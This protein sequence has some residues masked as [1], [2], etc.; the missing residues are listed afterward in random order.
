[1]RNK[2]I[3]NTIEGAAITLS[4]LLLSSCNGLFDGVYDEPSEGNVSEGE[5]NPSTRR[6]RIVVNASTFDKW[7]YINLHDR[8]VTAMDVPT[9]LT[10]EW[11][12]KSGITYHE[13]DLKNDTY[14]FRKLVKTDAM[15]EPSDW[16][17]AVHKFDSR[18]KDGGA[19]ETEFTSLDD[20]PSASEF[21]NVVFTEDV[22]SENSVMTDISG[23]LSYYIGY[24]NSLSNPVL[25]RWL[26]MDITTPPPT[27][28]PSGKV[29]IVRLHDGTMAALHLANYIS[30][31][32]LKGYLT[33]DYI[34]P[35]E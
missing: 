13:V 23:M 19:Y 20:L 9:L 22:W 16:D 31:N 3:T 1:M 10:G 33:I 32:N 5:Y 7:H 25:G 24:Q 30:P 8:S 11:D 28:H 15:P 26:V 27:Y 2:K 29:Y 14:T 18:I 4:L 6:G 17:F 21:S 12:G 35:Y 34:Y